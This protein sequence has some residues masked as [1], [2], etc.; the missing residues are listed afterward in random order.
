MTDDTSAAL[1]RLKEIASR[2]DDGVAMCLWSEEARTILAHIA[3][4][5]DRAEAAEAADKQ[6]VDA[7]EK[8]YARAKEAEA[9]V[10]AAEERGL[11][12]NMLPDGRLDFCAIREGSRLWDGRVR[13][14]VAEAREAELRAV[15]KGVD[16]DVR[17]HLRSDRVDHA[18]LRKHVVQMVRQALAAA[19]TAPTSRES[20]VAK[21]E[22]LLREARA[23]VEYIAD[24]ESGSAEGAAS[25][26]L[27]ADIDAALGDAP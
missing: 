27:L 13:A 10:A 19:P 7:F 11:V 16:D 17:H 4:L 2:R 8:A 3:D 22:R 15:L 5:E 9:K 25:R 1:E 20:R 18:V 21:L 23:D 12:F 24:A 14:E 6:A 26:D